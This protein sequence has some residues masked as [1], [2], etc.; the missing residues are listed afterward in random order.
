MNEALFKKSRS[1]GDSEKFV[2]KSQEVL[3]TFEAGQVIF[4]Q[5]DQGGDLL[6]VESGSVEIFISKNGQDIALAQMGAGEIIG[7]M[8]FLTHDSRLAS[9]RATK[10]TTIKRIPSQHVQKYIAS[11]PKWLN[12]VLKEFVGRINEMNR[13]Y[14]EVAIDLKKARDMQITPLFLATQLA[15]GLA[16]V[17]KGIMKTQDGIDIVFVE[18]LA[19]KMQLA[20]NQPKEMVDSLFSI[21]EL[22]SLLKIEIE[23]ERKRK[24]YRLS[25][26]E[27][28]AMFTQFVRDS[29]Q[30]AARKIIKARLSNR[31]LRV[32]QAVAKYSIKKGNG[33]DKSAPVAFSELK[34]HLKNVTGIDF[35]P[36]ALAKPAKL[37]LLVLKDEDQEVASVVMTPSSLMRTL[38][39]V[40][41]MRRL[42]G[43]EFE[44]E[45]SLADPPAFLRTENGAA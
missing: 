32:I 15:Q 5:G 41:A 12:I 21:F 37:G 22:S 16:L 20:L 25:N 7:V 23:P 24:V 2:V 43:E 38:A 42:M 40:Q 26:L 45:D 8:T 33:A 34:E 11:F 9:A 10:P 27:N 36:Q 31:E 1:D 19:E 3:Q 28:V 6:F 4:L 30:G 29:A 39:C 44:P 18:E 17:G 14:S 13:M 35:D